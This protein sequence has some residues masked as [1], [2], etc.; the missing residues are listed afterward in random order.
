[1]CPRLLCQPLGFQGRDRIVTIT[2]HLPT[3]AEILSVCD[4][5]GHLKITGKQRPTGTN[6][7][8]S[9]SER[10]PHVC[11]HTRS[12]NCGPFVVSVTGRD[13]EGEGTMSSEVC[14]CWM[15]TCMLCVRSGKSQF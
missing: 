11:V 4:C 3:D 10:A 5:L 8:L 14:F 12:Y 2:I 13:P 9:K 1:M 7:T 15:D 6:T